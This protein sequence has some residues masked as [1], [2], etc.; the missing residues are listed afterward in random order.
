MN[1]S[2]PLS[3]HFHTLEVLEE[4]ILMHKTYPFYS[5]AEKLRNQNL[6]GW[7]NQVQK[8]QIPVQESSQ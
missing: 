2:V 5:R 4:L 3:K 1:S 6:M 8:A 7:L